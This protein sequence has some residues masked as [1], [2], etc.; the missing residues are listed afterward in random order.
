MYHFNSAPVATPSLSGA[1][2]P[3]IPDSHK[4]KLEKRQIT[5]NRASYS[6]ATC[7]R[8]KVKCDKVHPICGGCEKAGEQC[9]YASA[10]GDAQKTDSSK[11]RQSHGE[12]PK[13]RKMTSGATALPPSPENSQHELSSSPAHIHAIEAQLKRL[14]ALVETLK[15]DANHEPGHFD[16]RLTPASSLPSTSEADSDDSHQ[17]SKL[18]LGMFQPDVTGLS[19]PLSSLI[20][21]NDGSPIQEDPFWT[22]ISGEVNELNQMMHR[23]N[24]SYLVA[25]GVKNQSCPATVSETL[26]AIHPL[27]NKDDLFEPNSFHRVAG[28]PSYSVHNLDSNCPECRHL[29]FAKSTLLQDI[30]LQ[31]LPS[32]AKGHLLGHGPTRVQSNVLLRC[33]LSNVH[34]LL[35]VLVPT[36]IKSIH[37]HFWDRFHPDPDAYSNYP[38]LGPAA[39]IFAIWYA[40]VLSI[41]ESGLKKWFP[42][43]S[44]AKLSAIFHDKVILALHLSCFSRNT[45]LQTLAAYLIICSI[46]VAEEDPVQSSLYMQ[47][48]VRLALS[49]GLHREPSLFNMS[50][51]EEGLRRRLWWQIIQL[52]IS[53]VVASGYP[54]LISDAFCDTQISCEDNEKSP[55]EDSSRRSQSSDAS[56]T[57]PLHRNEIYK[58]FSLVAKGRSII[59]CATRTVASMHMVTRPLTNEDMQEIKTIIGAVR[60]QV[61]KIIQQIPAKGLPESGFV[62]HDSHR[63]PGRKRDTDAC[64]GLAVDDGELAFYT[65]LVENPNAPTPFEAYHRQRLAAFY[66]WARI[67]LSMGSEKLNCAAYVPFLKNIKSKVW[68]VARQCALRVS[69]SFLRKLVSLAEDPDLEQFRWS[70]LLTHG[71]VQPAMIVLVDLYERPHSIEAARSRELIDQVFSWSNP[72]RGIVGGPNGVTVQ[73]PLRE[74]GVEAWDMLRG[75]RSAAWQKA[76]LEPRV[77]WTEADQIEIGVAKPLTETEK[78]AQSIREDSFHD[79]AHGHVHFEPTSASTSTQ[80]TT[81]PNLHPSMNPT[82]DEPPHESDAGQYVSSRAQRNHFL[83][84]IENDERLDPKR[85]L[86]RLAHQQRMPFPLS[87]KLEACSGH[88]SNHE[89]AGAHLIV[90]NEHV[91]RPSRTPVAQDTLWQSN[92]SGQS[93]HSKPAPQASGLS[94]QE[95]VQTEVNSTIPTNHGAVNPS[96]FLNEPIKNEVNSRLEFNAPAPQSDASILDLGFDWERWD[97]VFGQYSGFTEIMEDVQWN[98]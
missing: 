52:D 92:Q 78:I 80:S 20:I 55:T 48:L 49:M 2:H 59:S 28:V 65:S 38:D 84:Q 13:K 26:A 44:R 41:S 81:L 86:A 32:T 24:N 5:R 31:S 54:S 58:I 47:L 93:G 75:L 6:C 39:L 76:G 68:N 4:A 10:E 21:H 72:E 35:P 57:A 29:P 51:A 67:T 25:G 8:R 33:W 7:R 77:L 82:E 17:L 90:L 40:G 27:A 43:Q 3:H 45:N 94:T 74:G 62:P 56:S 22:H 85:G 91:P 69:Q 14:T 19:K 73:R 66:K 71:P 64:M 89:A 83:H 30:P 63:Q 36:D 11:Q 50:P 9:V 53:H 18:G 98:E 96:T 42:K 46:P 60:A 34:P 70:W 1:T 87:G 95:G 23:Q 37:E 97:S 15:R 79:S 12:E 88:A 16:G 61:E